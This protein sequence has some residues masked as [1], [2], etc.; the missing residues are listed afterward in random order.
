VLIKKNT[1]G[2]SYIYTLANGLLPSYLH[3]RTTECTKL[4][5]SLFTYK[6]AATA[7]FTQKFEYI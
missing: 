3:V 5:D 4:E 1:G 2:T 6:H 7:K